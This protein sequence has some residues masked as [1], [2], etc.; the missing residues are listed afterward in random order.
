MNP[1]LSLQISFLRPICIILMMS[2]HVNPGFDPDNFPH[3]IRGLAQFEVD[4]LGRASVSTLSLI[5]GFLIAASASRKTFGSH[6]LLRFQTLFVPALVWNVAFLALVQIGFALTGSSFGA[7]DRMSEIGYAELIVQRVLFLYGEPGT[8]IIEF[9]RDL[10]V[11]SAIVIALTRMRLSIVTLAFAVVFG[12]TL[13]DSMAPV[14]YR[15]TILLFML[16]GCL[17][18]RICGGIEI[19]A[20]VL[21]AALPILVYFVAVQTGLLRKPFAEI[22]MVAEAYNIAGRAALAV[23]ALW[24]SRVAVGLDWGRRVASLSDAAYLAFLSHTTVIS[25]LWFVWKMAFG[26]VGEPGYALF[27][28]GAPA[29]AFAVALVAIR[30]LPMFWAPAQIAVSGRA[31][32]S[33]V[34]AGAPSPEIASARETART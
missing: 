19:R 30:F 11:A 2:V 23:Y 10:F 18:Y 16:G 29:V 32:R 22:G 33:K 3:L 26:G 6:I 21:W 8:P 17:L 5:S 27:F 13:Y 20:A 9:L 15:E 31:V 25:L 34:S 7:M 24:L 12:L 28:F 4:V 14:L 1:T